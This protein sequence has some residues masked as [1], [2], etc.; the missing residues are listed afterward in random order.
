MSVICLT[1]EDNDLTGLDCYETD[2]HRQAA[3]RNF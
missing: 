1:R 3:L 2:M